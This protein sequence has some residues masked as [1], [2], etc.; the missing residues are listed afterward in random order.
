MWAIF[1]FVVERTVGV[2]SDCQSA[3]GLG[4][5]GVEVHI[6]HTAESRNTAYVDCETVVIDRT[7][8]MEVDGQRTG[9]GSQWTE[10]L[11]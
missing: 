6:Q 1:N 8:G 7:V 9:F 3:V 10:G 4:H 11:E 2:P 5:G